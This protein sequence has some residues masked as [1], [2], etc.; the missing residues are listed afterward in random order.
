[1][2]SIRVTSPIL[3]PVTGKP[4]VR[5]L[6]TEEISGPTVTG[7]RQVMA[8]H[9][10]EGLTPRRLGSILAAAE[11]GDP[12]SYLEL[13][14]DIE[15][16]YLHYRAV[17]GT[18]RLSVSQLDV[19]VEAAS[20]SPDDV[21]AA[22]LA[23]TVVADDAFADVLYDLLDGLG[24]GFSVA[25]VVW[26]TS[27]QQ[28][29]P[30]R[31]VWRDPR[32]FQFD[33]VDGTTLRLRDGETP[34]GRNL[35][36]FK[37]IVHRPRTKSGIPIRGGLARPAC[38]A[39]LFTG[40]ATKDWA[41]FTETYGQPL[42]VGR[43]GPGAS[44]EDM[45]ALLRAVRNIAADAAAIIPA[46][47][48][49]EFVEATKASANAAVFE[50]LIS[51]FE[52]Q[53]SKLVLGQTATTDAIA[54]GHA[55]GQE[56]RQV[57]EDIERADARQLVTT[58]R[59]WLFEPMTLLNFGDRAAC[60]KL[61]IGR[62]ESEDLKLKLDALEKLVPLGLRVSMTEVRDTY[63][64]ADPD[65]ADEVLTAPSAAPLPAN[66]V[67][68]NPI[69]PPAGAVPAP[70]AR[71]LASQQPTRPATDADPVDGMVDELLADW[72]PLA[73]P[74]VTAILKAAEQAADAND[75]VTRL[76]TVAGGDHTGALQDAL[77]RGQFM[78]RVA[79]RV[80]AVGDANA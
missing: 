52:R 76:M 77:A 13:A 62:P 65:P 72:E 56:H 53:T 6:L 74:L 12:A 33:R 21:A 79:A 73:G 8:E 42:R 80:G 40:Y 17:L 5:E 28:W 36:P 25:E 22:D 60:P 66:P 61:R 39:W 51:F 59:R 71:A 35:E 3:D 70:G 4:I 29:M 54:G 37:Y 41:A 58:L 67:P 46:S 31:I 9:P 23:R 63:G 20:D 32:W 19:T 64:F 30:A 45:A 10:S 11:Q 18:R 16:K 38:W 34:D 47:M 27:G 55:V 14:E 26:D 1:M 48:Q 15:E 50:G 75:F 24:K 2:A 68:A 57:Q 49:L 7:V 78:A 43:Y 69:S 44:K